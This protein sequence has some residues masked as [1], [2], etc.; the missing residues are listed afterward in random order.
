MYNRLMGYFPRDTDPKV[1]EQY[2]EMLRNLPGWRKLE[3]VA[4]I[5]RAV[6]E[7][8]LAGLR[9]TFPNESEE[10]L[11]RR[12]ADLLYGQEL[13]EKAYGHHNE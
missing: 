4:E 3:M 1:E 11:Q 9:K 2:F 10:N 8:N 7:L 12:L 13:A 5:N 6:R